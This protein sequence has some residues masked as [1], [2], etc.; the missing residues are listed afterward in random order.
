ME[1]DVKLLG[2]KPYYEEENIWLYKGDCREIVKQ[3]NENLID[4]IVTSPPYNASKE[5]ESDMNE[6]EYDLFLR[7]VVDALYPITRHRFVLNV[8][9][10]MQSKKY[11]N[12]KILP[13]AL[14]NLE[15]YTLKDLIVW[16]QLNTESDTAWGSWRSAAAPHFRHQVEY[17]I[18][19]H[20]GEWNI[21]RG[22]SD[23]ESREFTRYT[24]DHW[25]IPCARKNGHPAPFPLEL[26]SRIIK[27]LSFKNG[28][29]LD[30]FA[31]SGTTLIAAKRL[32][33]RAI[34][35][36]ID[37]TYCELITKRLRQGDLFYG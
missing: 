17:I 29:I 22:E 26:A 31:G 10:D 20:K 36:E 3:F 35:I 37:E 16:N 18:L 12:M 15:P 4:L 27:L 25:K 11:G 7:S 9:F 5:Y 19:A 34:G 33:R 6:T 24:L 23:I 14:K 30:P 13:I 1:V 32:G 28:L 21:G 8:P 2:V